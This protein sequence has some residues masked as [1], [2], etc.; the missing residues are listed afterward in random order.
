MVKCEYTR[1]GGRGKRITSDKA[2]RAAQVVI[3][4]DGFQYRVCEGCADFM[5]RDLRREGRGDV[6]RVND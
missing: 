1:C 6:R 4:V 3:A 2:R 5:L